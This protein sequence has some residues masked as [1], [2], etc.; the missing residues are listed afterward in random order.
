MFITE[1]S[2]Q[3]VSLSGIILIIHLPD[4]HNQMALLPQ[5]LPSLISIYGLPHV[6]TIILPGRPVQPLALCPSSSSGFISHVGHP[7]IAAKFTQESECSRVVEGEAFA[8]RYTLHFAGIG[9]LA[10]LSNLLG[11]FCHLS[12]FDLLP[13]HAD[14]KG[15]SDSTEELSLSIMAECLSLFMAHRL[16]IQ[17][18]IDVPRRR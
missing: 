7:D 2:L 5:A 18:R 15:L 12:M 1:Y 6:A 11:A 14:Y 13:T 4:H 10:A 17:N 16:S 3:H 8:L 9:L